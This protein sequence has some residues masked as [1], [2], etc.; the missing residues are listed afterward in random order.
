MH[1]RTQQLEGG[2]LEAR[3]EL[4][5]TVPG[6]L[7]ERGWAGFRDDRTR[8]QREARTGQWPLAVAQATETGTTLSLP[9]FTPLSRRPWALSGSV[10][11]P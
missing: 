4:K 5:A 11:Q 2:P 10:H 3:G 7:K 8:R 9:N 1:G 6:T